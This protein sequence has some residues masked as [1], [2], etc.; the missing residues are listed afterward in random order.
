MR[1]H[2]CYIGRYRVLRRLQIDFTPHQ[3]AATSLGDDG[4]ALDFLVGPNGSGKST[5]L[6]ALAEIFARLAYDQ[7]EIDFPFMVDYDQHEDSGT[8]RITITN[9]DWE[10][11]DDLVG[12]IRV[13]VDDRQVVWEERTRKR[14]L[15]KRIVVIT[16]GRED[17]WRE[18][19]SASVRKVSDR[20]PIN[21]EP[22]N[23]ELIES[24]ALSELPGMLAI[25]AA[26]QM[27]ETSGA[28]TLIPADTLSLVTLCA[29]LAEFNQAGQISRLTNILTETKITQV[30]GFTLTFRLNQGVTLAPDRRRIEGLQPIAT[31]VVQTGSDRRLYFDLTTN[32]IKVAS[33]LFTKLGKAFDVYAFLRR[34]SASS[35]TAERTFQG[36][37]IFVRRGISEEEQR[38][39]LENNRDELPQ[40]LQLLSQF[41]DGERS[42]L[43]RMSLFSMLND[44]PSL[45]LLDEPEVHFNDYWKRQIVLYLHEALREQKSHALITTHTSITL[46]DVAKE[47]I[48]VLYRENTHAEKSANPSINTLAADPSDIIGV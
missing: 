35:T 15:P 40:S 47:D 17:E 39:R 4:V 45:I 9:C 25:S 43:G 6:Q 42:F 23:Q 29:L 21:S 24:R 1:L 32:P 16:T 26:D 2:R 27:T 3:N 7:P 30:C 34:L 19:L 20:Q 14:Y 36:V 48:L 37:D 28:V 13:F 18:L 8:R 38:R 22:L 12:D 41:S 33:Q 5:V 10:H 31:R 11:K 44:Q 46:T